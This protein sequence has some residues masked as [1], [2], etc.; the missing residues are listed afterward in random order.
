[1]FETPSFALSPRRA[2]AAPLPIE[3]PVFQCA[4]EARAPNTLA[5]RPRS[6]ATNHAAS[7][8]APCCRRAALSPRRAVAAP[9][10]RRAALSPRRAVAAPRCRRAALS[11]RRAVATPR[12]RRAALSPRRA[13]AARAVAAPRCRR[14]RCRRAA[15]SPRRAVTAPW[16]SASRFSCAREARAKKNRRVNVKT[17]RC[18]R[19]CA[20]F[21]LVLLKISA[22]LGEMLSHVVDTLSQKFRY[23]LTGFVTSSHKSPKHLRTCDILSQ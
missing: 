12:C 1:M 18:V 14:A 5:Q 19:V 16:P 9:C 13:V 8:S 3:H 15:L 11:P 7:L 2:V 22:D 17:R 4:R 23:P 6:A 21:R 10:C 20:P